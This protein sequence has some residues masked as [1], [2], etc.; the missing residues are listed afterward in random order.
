MKNVVDICH[1]LFQDEFDVAS[2]TKQ[3]K[4]GVSDGTTQAAEYQDPRGSVE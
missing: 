2:Q 3:V 4:G 1:I